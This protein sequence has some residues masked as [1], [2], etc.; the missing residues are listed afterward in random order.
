[1]GARAGAQ[2]WPV[3]PF[4]ARVVLQG[5]TVFADGAPVEFDREALRARMRET[6]IDVLVDLAQG[7]ERALG[8]AGGA[9]R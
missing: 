7:P 2:G 5:V 3:D 8:G 1:M 9:G 4:K 6:R